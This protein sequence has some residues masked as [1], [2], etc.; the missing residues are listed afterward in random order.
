M[1]K[2]DPTNSNTTHIIK[3]GN[4]VARVNQQGGSLDSIF[5]T[6]KAVEILGQWQSTQGPTSG[7]PIFPV[8]GAVSE[9]GKFV[10][11]GEVY[12][13]GKHGY[14]RKTQF[15]CVQQTE[16]SIILR[17]IHD[18]EQAQGIYPFR[19]QIELEYF[20]NADGVTSRMSI[21]NL[22]ERV[23]YFGG[24]FHPA[25]VWPLPGNASQDGHSLTLSSPLSEDTAV[26]RPIEG[27]TYADNSDANPFD[28][29]GVW[30]LA[31]QQ[32]VRDAFFMIIP[33]KDRDAPI[34]LH[35]QGKPD[36]VA[37]NVTMKGWEGFGIWTKPDGKTPIL[38]VEPLVGVS[39]IDSADNMPELEKIQGLRR[40]LPGQT[41]TATMTIAPQ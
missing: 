2:A 27:K 19:H 41:F 18:P 12:E 3:S 38:C 35:F 7:Y 9:S 26:F 10:Y 31:A 14:A 32:F 28:Q 21:T 20:I 25:L 33:E 15:S 39:L 30:H 36:G 23:M 6:D 1:D 40:L 16:D 37:V 4:L 11:E 5:M 24:G 8:V 17:Y 29:N 22:D 34:N 13:P